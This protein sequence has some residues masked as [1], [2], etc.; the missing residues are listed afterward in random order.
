MTADLNVLMHV[1]LEED[2]EA[3]PVPAGEAIIY[4]QSELEIHSDSREWFGKC[5]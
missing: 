5:C 1:L 2:P 3:E 4:F